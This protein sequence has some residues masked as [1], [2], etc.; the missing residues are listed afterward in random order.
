MRRRREREKNTKS[1]NDSYELVWVSRFGAFF[2][3]GAIS[4]AQK[5]KKIRNEE[6]RQKTIRLKVCAVK[7]EIGSVTR[8]TGTIH[9]RKVNDPFSSANFERNVIEL[10]RKNGESFH[11]C[12]KSNRSEFLHPLPLR[13]EI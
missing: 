4:Q 12:G 10:R 11:V 1:R 6:W 9:K 8:V 2:Q 3:P 5:E 13:P 7:I